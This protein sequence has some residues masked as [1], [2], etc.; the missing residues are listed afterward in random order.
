MQVTV[1]DLL[2]Q[3]E[4]LH[5]MTPEELSAV[6]S[7]W[8]RPGRQEVDDPSRFCEWLRVN[9][10]MTEFVISVLGKG[11]ADWLILNQYRLTDL[12]NSGA[13]AG[14]FLAVDC[15]GQ[16]VRLQIVSPRVARGPDWY[17]IALVSV[18][19]LALVG[20]SCLLQFQ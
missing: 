12:L 9:D 13:Q 15:M 17:E 5:L 6:R 11:K 19:S 20:V 2:S 18:M 16:G 7:R 1:E 14:D 8:F 10:Y 3:I 4:K